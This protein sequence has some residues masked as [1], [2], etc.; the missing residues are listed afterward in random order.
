MDFVALIEQAGLRV[1]NGQ[2]RVQAA[3]SAGLVVMAGDADGAV[4]RIAVEE[5]S[6][7]VEEVSGQQAD[8]SMVIVAP[9]GPKT[10]H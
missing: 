3:L 4:Y 1:L 5:N 7:V 10:L 6:L 9:V 8:G 2:R